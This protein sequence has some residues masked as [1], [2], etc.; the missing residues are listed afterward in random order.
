MPKLS[1]YFFNIPLLTILQA[2]VTHSKYVYPNI[3]A[4]SFCPAP[5]T[6]HIPTPFSFT[7]IPSVT[8][9]STPPHNISYTGYMVIEP[10]D[11]S[12]FIHISPNEVA[13]PSADR[14]DIEYSIA[15]GMFYY[16]L[17]VIGMGFRDGK[18]WLGAS[19]P[20]CPSVVIDEKGIKT[21]TG[22]TG[23]GGATCTTRPVNL[24]AEIC[25]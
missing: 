18:I 4:T 22:K 20:G 23:N 25:V 21:W 1:H 2:M 12:M 14:V 7:P 17:K 6:L 5:M 19:D 15:W 13:E 16:D 8:L 11:G 9:S 10:S 3:T 24:L